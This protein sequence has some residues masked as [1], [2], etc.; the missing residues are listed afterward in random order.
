MRSSNSELQNKRIATHYSKTSSFYATISMH[1]MPQQMQT[2]IA[3][4][5][6]KETNSHLDKKRQRPQL[7]RKR[8]NLSPR[9]NVRLPEKTNVSYKSCHSNL[10]LDVAVPT[11]FPWNCALIWYFFFWSLRLLSRLLKSTLLFS[12]LLYTRLYSTSTLLSSLL[13]SP[14]RCVSL[15]LSCVK[16]MPTGLADLLSYFSTSRTCQLE[17][18]IFGVTSLLQE[19]A[20]WTSWSLELLLY[21]RNVPTGLNDLL[22]YFSTSGTCQ[23][24][25]MM[26]WATSLLQERANCTYWSFEPLLYFRNVPTGLNDLLSY[27]STSGTCQLDFMIFWATSL[28]QER[29]N[30]T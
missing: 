10:I 20:N 13:E 3:Q 4:R 2:S 23:L 14:P 21:F 5:Q 8:A 18:M 26:F 27:F 29:A 12:S 1:K 28:L 9:R 30:W 22:S 24:D 11:R 15:Q 6:Q 7:S 19:R 16:T 17:F 25:L